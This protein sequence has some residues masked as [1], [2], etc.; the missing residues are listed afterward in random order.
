MSFVLFLLFVPFLSINKEHLYTAD[1]DLFSTICI[2]TIV[3]NLFLL[4]NFVYGTICH[5]AFK[6]TL[7][8]VKY[9]NFY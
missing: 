1:T 4:I 8:R 9:S 6:K 3:L 5:K 2:G 7:Y